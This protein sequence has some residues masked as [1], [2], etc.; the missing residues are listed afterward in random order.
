MDVAI[1]MRY[2]IPMAI[3]IRSEVAC[4]ICLIETRHWRK[5]LQCTYACCPS[6]WK[7]EEHES[8]RQKA[9]ESGELSEG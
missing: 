7:D 9:R 2:K 4:G 6:C 8:C 5:C 3:L 1:D